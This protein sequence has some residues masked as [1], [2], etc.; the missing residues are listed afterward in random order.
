MEVMSI[1][2]QILLLNG[3]SIVPNI[4]IKHMNLQRRKGTVSGTVSGLNAN[5][6]QRAKLKVE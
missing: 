3:L 2:F 5:E 6:G 1:L 4:S